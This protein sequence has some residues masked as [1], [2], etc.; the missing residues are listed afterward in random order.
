MKA[1]AALEYLMTYGWAILII[2][3]AI[4]ALYAMGVFNVGAGST[5]SPCFAPGADFTYQQHSVVSDILYLELQ[6]GPNAISLTNVT[7]TTTTGATYNET[8]TAIIAN[9][10]QI[11]KVDVT[12]ITSASAYSVD[13]AITYTRSGVPHQE[14]ATLHV[15][16]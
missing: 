5:C 1:Q 10:N 15:S 9:A 13:L 4:G 11:I 3:I 12:G 2:V 6:E 8:A 14:T 7:A 16:P